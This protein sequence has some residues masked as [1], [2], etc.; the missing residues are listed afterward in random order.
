VHGT[1]TIT[2]TFVH[3]TNTITETEGF[4]MRRMLQRLFSDRN[5][6]YF[7]CTKISKSTSERTEVSF[8]MSK[9]KR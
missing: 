1:N 2:E 4:N 3:G 7:L 6:T 8:L 5:K 9:E